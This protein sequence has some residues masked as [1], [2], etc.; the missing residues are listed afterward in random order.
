VFSVSRQLC[1]ARLKL[2]PLL[3]L[4]LAVKSNL[5]EL[6]GC[7][8]AR[9]ALLGCPPV[10]LELLLLALL[11]RL[12]LTPFQGSPDRAGGVASVQ[13]LAGVLALAHATRP[14]VFI[15]CRCPLP[16]RD[17]VVALEPAWRLGV[18]RDVRR[19]GF[20]VLSPLAH[21]VARLQIRSGSRGTL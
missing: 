10:L 16:W 8:P 17:L 4:A 18:D 20:P 3:T 19:Y 7:C 11:A 12:L 15:S 2:L 9:L 13:A 14:F 5:D 6:A 1:F 21:A